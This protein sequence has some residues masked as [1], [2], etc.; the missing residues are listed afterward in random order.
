MGIKQCPLMSVHIWELLHRYSVQ[1][2][3]IGEWRSTGRVP[4]CGNRRRSKIYDYKEG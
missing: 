3:E 1:Y 2:M 4:L